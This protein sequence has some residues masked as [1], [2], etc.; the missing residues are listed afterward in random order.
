[1]NTKPFVLLVI[2]AISNALYSDA[3]EPI[4]A[5]GLRPVDHG[6]VGAGEGPAWHPDGY[7]LFTG[8]GR[9]TKW[10]LSGNVSV[11]R[12]DS[13]GANGLLLDHEGRLIACEAGR[14]RVTRTQRDGRITVLADNYRGSRFNTPNDLAIDSRGRI[15]FT[16]PRYGSR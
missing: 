1:M 2:L 4:L 3:A 6:D 9:I 10:E 14:R 13:G 16:D 7:L 8:G 11:F 15:Y 5:R 12:E